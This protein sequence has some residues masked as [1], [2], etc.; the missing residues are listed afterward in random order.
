MVEVPTKT[1]TTSKMLILSLL[2][3]DT[4]VGFSSI[5]AADVTAFNLDVVG[6][7]ESCL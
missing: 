6:R 7:F 3:E 4:A 1:T 5:F 2:R